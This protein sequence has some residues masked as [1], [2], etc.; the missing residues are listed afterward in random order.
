MG[1]GD[2]VGAGTDR[3]GRRLQ[4]LGAATRSRADDFTIGGAF[5]VGLDL[6]QIEFSHAGGP[7]LAFTSQ[8]GRETDP[9]ATPPLDGFDAVL[10]LF[11]GTGPPATLDLLNDDGC[12]VAGVVLPACTQSIGGTA[13]TGGAAICCS[14]SRASPPATTRSSCRPSP[15]TP[16]GPTLDDGYNGNVS[17]GTPDA[18]FV[19]PP[20]RVHLLGI[21]E[22]LSVQSP[23]PVSI[24]GPFASPDA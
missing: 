11:V 21:D 10:A 13:F 12:T 6:L 23:N 1:G 3:A 16:N 24:S 5:S 15:N 7:F 4:V 18:G 2:A 19:A 22:I 20:F 8:R 9:D 14:I 17:I